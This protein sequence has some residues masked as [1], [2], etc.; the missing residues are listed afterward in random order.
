MSG[1]PLIFDRA[2]LRQR[3]ARA[4]R[5]ETA[6]D[7][8]LDR[9][10]DDV[11]DRLAFIQRTFENVLVIGAHGGRIAAKLQSAHRFEHLVETE[12]MAEMLS[13]RAGAGVVADE[14]ALP[15]APGSFDLVIAGP[16]L[17]F[18]ND[19]PGVL[20][21]IRQALRPDGLFLSGLFGGTTLTELRQAW[22]AAETEVMGGVSPRVSP[23]ADVR[24]LGGLLQR[25]RFALPVVDADVFKV[26]YGSALDLMQDL[27]AMGAGNVMVDRSRTPVSRRLLRRAVEIYAD[28]FA[29][30]NG[31]IPAT[32]ELLVMT[33]W[34]PHDNQ[35]KPLKPGSA[36]ARLADAL[37]V[38][39]GRLKHRED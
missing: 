17:Q 8:L 16:T 14:E 23:F 13:G 35:Q 21:Q 30:A 1:A 29:D 37:G 7:F 22:V 28:R 3:R 27:R 19:L 26:R 31:R 11:A 10:T 39:E 2:L 6:P 5:A 25:A 4:A 38:A 34:S 12:T 20:M 9:F 15:F 18:V 24:D 36:T 33:A 32:F